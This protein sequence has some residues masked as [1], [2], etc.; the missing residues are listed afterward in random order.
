MGKERGVPGEQPVPPGA[1]GGVGQGHRAHIPVSAGTARLMTPAMYPVLRSEHGV[2][3]FLHARSKR[4]DCSPCG[5]PRQ[6]SAKE[7]ARQGRRRDT[8]S[9]PGFRRPPGEG[10][11]NPLQYSGLGNPVDSRTAVHGVT[12]ESDVTE[13]LSTGAHR[14][15]GSP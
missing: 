7:P 9:I 4:A 13:W 12:E 10:N 15:P 8:G 3:A 11:G 1:G 14:S 5:L 2:S 6:C